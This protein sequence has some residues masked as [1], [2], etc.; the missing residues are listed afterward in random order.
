MC[1]GDDDKHFE[2]LGLEHEEDSACSK[3]KPKGKEGK[4][5]ARTTKRKGTDTHQRLFT[6]S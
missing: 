6:K 5:N 3:R 2:E 1:V 4:I